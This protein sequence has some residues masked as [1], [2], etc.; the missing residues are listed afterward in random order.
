MHSPG[1]MKELLSYIDIVYIRLHISHYTILH[2]DLI[3]STRK[4]KYM[5]IGKTEIYI[6]AFVEV[7]APGH[8]ISMPRSAD[9][10][11]IL[12]KTETCRRLAGAS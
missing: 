10:N 2:V 3:L 5:L 9:E 12:L 7:E 6:R 8:G 1:T 11:S 4:G